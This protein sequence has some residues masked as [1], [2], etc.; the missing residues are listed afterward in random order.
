SVGLNP[1][2]CWIQSESVSADQ[3]MPKCIA[4]TKGEYPGIL[5][6]SPSAKGGFFVLVFARIRRTAKK[7]LA[8]AP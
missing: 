4:L 1:E 3:N 7:Q 6:L 5:C 2:I 8:R